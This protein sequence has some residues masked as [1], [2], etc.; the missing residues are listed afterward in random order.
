VISNR[1]AEVRIVEIFLGFLV[2]TRFGSLSRVPK[3]VQPANVS[4]DFCQEVI[5]TMLPAITSR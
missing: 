1:F 4:A 3:F 5:G 2:A